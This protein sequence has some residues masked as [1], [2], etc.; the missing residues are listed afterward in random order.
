MAKIT[1]VFED[2]EGGAYRADVFNDTPLP[3]QLD[4]CTPAQRVAGTLMYAARTPVIYRAVEDLVYRMAE[5]VPVKAET[6]TQP[7]EQPARA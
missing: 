7:L 4:Q 3:E 5:H 6:G 1:V 2:V